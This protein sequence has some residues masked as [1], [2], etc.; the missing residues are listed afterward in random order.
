[1]H[2]FHKS[3]SCNEKHITECYNLVKIKPAEK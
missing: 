2:G 1:M 3:Q